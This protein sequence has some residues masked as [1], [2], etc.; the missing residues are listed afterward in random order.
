[1]AGY[2]PCHQKHRHLKPNFH[3]H[4]N[5]YVTIV[6]RYR[7]RFTCLLLA[8]L[9][10]FALSSPVLQRVAPLVGVV[11]P[12]TLTSAAP[13]NFAMV[14]AI[15]RE[16]PPA[17]VTSTSSSVLATPTT[18][19]HLKPGNRYVGYGNVATTLS[20]STSASPAP[21]VAMGAAIER[22]RDGQIS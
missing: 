16:A 12:S 2:P 17:V 20:T 15:Q 13:A 1:M 14:D 4:L 21:L 9:S 5:Y 3:T 22:N 10:S 8:C 6:S 18:P 7:M 19:T 11:I